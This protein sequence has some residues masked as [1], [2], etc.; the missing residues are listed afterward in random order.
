MQKQRLYRRAHG[1]EDLDRE[2]EHGVDVRGIVP[3]DDGLTTKERAAGGRDEGL[4]RRMVHEM[5]V[6]DGRGGWEKMGDRAEKALVEEG[7]GSRN[8]EDD[9]V[10]EEV[11]AVQQQ[12][13]APQQ[14]QRRRGHRWFGIWG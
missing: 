13:S 12:Q 11:V 2:E 3:W 14:Q 5:V 1:I 10:Q 8:Q 7:R 4:T 9:V 6:P